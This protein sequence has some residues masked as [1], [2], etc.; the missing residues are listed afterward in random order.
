MSVPSNCTVLVIGGGPSGSYAATVLAREGVDVVLLEADTFP[1]YHIGESMLPSMRYFLRFVELEELFDKHQFE[2]KFGST[3]KLSGKREAY[4]DFAAS[5]GPGG[6]SWNLIRSESDEMI[7]R[8]AGECGAH[9]FDGTKV[10]DIKFI[11]YGNEHATA[12]F[13]QAGLASLGRPVS[14]QW[15]S[16]D[17]SSGTLNFEYLIDASGRAGIVSTKYL[18]NRTPNEALKNIANWAYWRGATRYGVDTHRENSPFFEALQDKSGWTW[19]IPLHDGTVSV[20]TVQRQSTFFAKKKAR[21]FETSEENYKE[22]LKLVPETNALLN[23]AYIVSEIKQATDWSY[24]SS[25]YAGPHL[26]IVGDAGCFI[27]PFFSSGVH[28]AMFGALSAATSIQA[29]RRG[30]CDE[31][32]AA[33]W[34]SSKVTEGYTRFLIIVMT[35][36][37]QIRNPKHSLL[38]DENEDGYDK[39]FEKIQSSRHPSP[40][41][42]ITCFT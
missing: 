6:H 22:D 2:K 8:Y 12:E 19:I 30:D 5:L 25:H 36:M 42:N 15:S 10:T 14:A 17:G 35:I 40:I 31:L 13:A 3:F 23:N 29:A 28:L 33:K 20:G 11:P 27:D 18:K 32:S 26:R 4:T 21:G 37:R 24:S 7:F 16:K 9:V 41:R 38:D 1:R 39:A 34:H